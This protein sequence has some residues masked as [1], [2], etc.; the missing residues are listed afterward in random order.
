MDS[1]DNLRHSAAHLL[2]AAVLKLWPDAKRAIGPPIEDGFYYDFEFSQPISEL[3]L[4]NIEKEMSK[5]DQKKEEI[6]QKEEQEAVEAEEAAEAE[7]LEEADEPEEVEEPE[8]VME[9]PEVEERDNKKDN[10]QNSNSSN[11]GDQ[12]TTKTEDN[13]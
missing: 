12:S 8:E 11:Q 2:A 3:D 6:E 7:E 4:K 5:D 13:E 9:Q 10:S 1:L